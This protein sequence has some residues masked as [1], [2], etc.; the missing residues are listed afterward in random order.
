MLAGLLRED[1]Q[2]T[3][4]ILETLSSL[5]VEEQMEHEVCQ[6]VTASVSSSRAD[7]LPAILRFL[8]HHLSKHN[9]HEITSALR[10][11]LSTE[12][13]AE[14]PRRNSRST[15][16]KEQPVGEALVLDA[17]LTSLRLRHD[18]G[19]LFLTQLEAIKRASDHRPFDWWLLTALSSAGDAKS[20]GRAAKLLAER[21][22]K[23]MLKPALMRAA[24]IGHGVALKPHYALMLQLAGGLV[25]SASSANARALGALVYELLFE[26]YVE[27]YER[28]EMIGHMLTH[29]GSG[30]GAEVDVALHV[31]VR[32]SKRDPVGVAQF[33]S[34]LTGVLDYV[35]ALTVPQARLAFELFARIAYDAH[36]G[37]SRLADELQ[38][39]IRKQL[40]ST[41]PRYKSLGV[42]G[43]CCLLGRLGARQTRAAEVALPETCVPETAPGSQLGSQMADGDSTMEPTRKAEAEA[44]L[45]LMLRYSSAPDGSFGFLLHELSLLVAARS[46]AADA[47]SPPEPSEDGVGSVGAETPQIEREV[48]DM[49]IDRITSSFE[50]EYLNDIEAVPCVPQPIRGITPSLAM[51]LDGD[52]AAIAVNVL[53]LLQHADVPASQRHALCTLSA[54]FQLLRVCEAA[55]SSDGQ[56]LEAVDAVLGCPLYLFD[57]DTLLGFDAKPA[58]VRETVCLALFYTVDW[59]RELVNAFCTQK[60]HSMRKKVLARLKQLLWMERQLDMCLAA[61][62]SFRLPAAIVSERSIGKTKAKGAAAGKESGPEGKA[63]RKDVTGASKGGGKAKAPANGKAKAKL[64]K[65]RRSNGSDIDSDSDSEGV[66]GM[67]EGDDEDDD[68][69]MGAEDGAD[70][71]GMSAQGGGASSSTLPTKEKAVKA[72]AAPKPTSQLPS[73]THLGKVLPYLRGLSVDVCTLLTFVPAFD[74]QPESEELELNELLTPPSVHYLL[75]HLH[76]CL[77]LGLTPA[78]APTGFGRSGAAASS[79]PAASKPSISGHDLSAM[80]LRRLGPTALLRRLVPA[81]ATFRRHATMLSEIVPQVL[82]CP[83]HVHNV[84]AAFGANEKEDEQ[85]RFVEPA[86][87]L[88]LQSLR[89]LLECKQVGDELGQAALLEVLGAFEPEPHPDSAELT[90]ISQRDTDTRRARAS[91]KGGRRQAADS[92]APAGA[93]SAAASCCACFDFFEVLLPNLPSIALQAEVIGVCKAALELLSKHASRTS[94]EVEERRERLGALASS[95]LQRQRADDRELTSWREKPPPTLLVKTLF[96][97]EAAYCASPWELL[98]RWSLEVLP[99]ISDCDLDA[100]WEVEACP[101]LTK[102]SAPHFLSVLFTLLTEE[103]KRLPLPPA[104]KAGSGD[105]AGRRRRGSAADGADEEGDADARDEAQLA[106]GVDEGTATDLIARLHELSECFVQLVKSTRDMDFKKKDGTSTAVGRALNKAAIVASSRF[107]GIVNKQALPLMSAHFTPLSTQVCALLKAL[108][109]ATRLLQVHCTMVKERLQTAALQPAA[110]L[111]REL[112]ALVFQVKLL[113]K[114]N[115]VHEGFWMG[116]LKHKTISGQEVSSQMMAEEPAPKEPKKRKEA[117]TGGPDAQRKRKRKK[118][119]G[120]EQP[121]EGEREGE[122]EDE[123]GDEGGDEDEEV[124]AHELYMSQVQELEGGEEHADYDH[125]EED[126]E[127]EEDIEESDDEE[128]Y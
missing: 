62:P 14:E 80:E 13:L 86:L 46:S 122:G 103:A 96:E 100:E 70:R 91:G 101:L 97:V 6:L 36:A 50:S 127:G 74:E 118:K 128:E 121:G 84:E 58:E 125:G 35:D 79:A 66:A 9:A 4:P 83:S 81:L 63:G 22:G 2:L 114:V 31:L 72:K 105:R 24:I 117:G 53:P 10:S 25:R 71:G 49:I 20:R 7:D 1:S 64:K 47:A 5:H 116:N 93:K 126:E 19:S 39:T 78:A 59:L 38:I 94:A 65:A 21:A 16:A 23:G 27:P 17:L 32:L 95:C 3:A 40:T 108:Q 44:L 61:T 76:S 90:S 26:E 123:V 88:M 67:A 42:L 109:P 41:A 33:S 73:L 12:F 29:A 124:G 104:P 68:E 11:G 55:I 77:K 85:S 30:A 60:D 102:R 34:F 37:A 89:K 45:S 120:A 52:E 8:L 82:D 112:E 87:L 98:R 113:L 57:S 106:S 56:E 111:K 43:G 75:A 92:A 48:I 54:T 115:H 99:E 69:V 110:V 51:S 15:G 107:I 18:L 28:Q 119:A